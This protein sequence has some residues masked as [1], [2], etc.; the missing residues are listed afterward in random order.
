MTIGRRNDSLDQ[1]RAN[2]SALR[3]LAEACAERFDAQHFSELSM[4][5]SNDFESAIAEGAT[6]IRIG[7]SIF[8]QRPAT[9]SGYSPGLS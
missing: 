1:T 4:G 6:M 7:S 8:G 9:T 5:M 2:F 3:K